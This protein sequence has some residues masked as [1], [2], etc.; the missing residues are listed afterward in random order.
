MRKNIK[1]QLIGK[2]PNSKLFK[3]YKNSLIN[4]NQIQFE[5]S[6]GLVLGDASLN[7]CN[8]GK[9]F[10]LKF[11]W[12]DKNKPYVDHVYA[13]FDEAPGARVISP[14]LPHGAKK[15]ELALRVI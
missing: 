9:T 4:L 14:P 1:E 11:E 2:S 8:K 6:V 10:R 5:T 15:K 7:S 12:S 13:L 3:E